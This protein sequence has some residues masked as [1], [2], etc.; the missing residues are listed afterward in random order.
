MKDYRL[1]K[2]VLSYQASR[3]EQKP[4]KER[5]KDLKKMG[6]SREGTKREVF[7]RLEW[8]RSVHSCVGLMWLGAAVSY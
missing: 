4:R 5:K 7:N 2:I 3:A 6:T 1:P 8:R